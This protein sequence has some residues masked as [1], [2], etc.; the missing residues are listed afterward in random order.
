MPE[1]IAHALR[2]ALQTLIIV[3]IVGCGGGDGAVSPPACTIS[4]VTISPTPATVAAGSSTTLTANVTSANCGSLSTTWQSS[5]T[6]VATVDNAGVVHGIVPGTTT[7][8]AT[9]SGQSGSTVVTVGPGPIL[10]VSSVTPA[11]NALGVGIEGSIKVT[12]SE[13]INASTATAANVRL[14]AG[15]ASVAGA[16]TVAGNVVTLTP[17]APLTEFNTVYTVTVS[18]SLSST[19]GDYLAANQVSTFTTAFLDPIYYY[20]ITNELQGPAKALD[21]FNGSPFGCFI[22]GLG[23]FF[24]QFWYADPL[25]GQDGYYALRNSLQLDARQLD[26]SATQSGCGLV[27]TPTSG[28]VPTGQAWKIVPYGAAFPTGYRLQDLTFGASQSLDAP[29][30]NAGSTSIPSMQP[31]VAASSQVWYFTRSGHR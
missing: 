6:S 2:S 20:H 28:P 14:T 13:P 25:A 18:P 4:A 17:S 9:V 1:Q 23:N 5:A 30:A 31:T 10:T 7:I 27:P 29:A 22:A 15:A 19:A 21:T 8:T 12:F 24:G 11:A 16:I 26:G 3:A